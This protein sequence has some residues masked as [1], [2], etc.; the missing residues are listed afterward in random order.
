[1]ERAFRVLQL[2]FRDEAL[3]RVYLGTRSS[4]AAL[5]GAATEVLVELLSSPWREQVLGLL[6]DPMV[7]PTALSRSG[8][9]QRRRLLA[10]LL[11]SSSPILR[12]LT[13][14]IAAE[15]GWVEALPAL[16]T[17]A[18]EVGGEER[19]DVLAAIASLE[20]GGAHAHG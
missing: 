18:A 3:E 19:R 5:R 15:N 4:R 13:A 2:L 10:A 7:R 6:T 12:L 8:P 11:G 20:G 1:M 9:E 14:R 17:A 16:Q